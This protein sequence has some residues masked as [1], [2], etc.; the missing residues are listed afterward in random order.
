MKETEKDVWETGREP[1]ASD[2]LEAKCKRREFQEVGSCA[3]F[4]AEKCLN[5][6][7]TQWNYI[8]LILAIVEMTDNLRNW[9]V[10]HSSKCGQKMEF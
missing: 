10:Q 7:S 9:S 5:R 4:H 1:R 2:I 6:V 8:V 3:Q